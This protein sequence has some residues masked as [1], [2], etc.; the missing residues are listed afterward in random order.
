MSASRPGRRTAPAL[1]S[2]RARLVLLSMAITGAAIGFIYLYVVPQ[3]SS[4]LTAERRFA[5]NV[6]LQSLYFM[7]SP[8]VLRQ[9]Q[10][11]VRR[12]ADST[13]ALVVAK[14]ADS[15]AVAASRRTA[16][17]KPVTTTAD[18][19]A[20]TAG[21]PPPKHF[22]DRAMIRAAYPLL[23][24][25]DASAEEI[26]LGLAFLADQRGSL[27]ASETAKA[28]AEARKGETAK[29]DS[30]TAAATRAVKAEGETDQARKELIARRVSMKAWTQY[31]RAMFSAAEFR[32][33]D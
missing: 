13:A 31:A 33:I 16:L 1:R 7:N 11:L 21:P 2:V 20:N 9:A 22:D 26:T 6:P 14:V 5:T 25:R 3:L 17:K 4:S 32:F 10:A 27:L 29:P 28:A 24:G 15:S 12:L 19:I 18:T 8:F 30:G 23:Y